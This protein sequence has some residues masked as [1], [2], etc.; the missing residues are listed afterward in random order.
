MSI[1]TVNNPDGS[2]KGFAVHG[3]FPR[4]WVCDEGFFEAAESVGAVTRKSD[5][6]TVVNME[7]DRKAVYKEV[8]IT[9]DGRTVWRFDHAERRVEANPAGKV[10]GYVRPGRDEASRIAK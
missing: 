1:E 6:M 3:L 8:M 9:D 2:F 10:R 7:G 5:T 4:R